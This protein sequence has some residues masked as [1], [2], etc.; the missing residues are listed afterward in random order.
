MSDIARLK[1][2]L[3]EVEPVVLR[4]IEVPLDIKLDK[5][6]GIV[7]AAMGWE[8]YHL[9]EFRVGRSV[10][11]GTPDPNWP[12]TR[13]LPAKKASLADLLEHAKKTFA[14]VYDFGDDWMHTVKVEAI[15]P[16]K[17]DTLYPRLIAAAGRCPPEDCGGPWGYA[18]FQD[19]IADNKHENHADAVEWYGEAFDPK[20][21]DVAELT[22]NVERAARR[23]SGNKATPAVKRKTKPNL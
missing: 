23:L 5:L 6:H 22:K 18:D 19:A 13:T 9:Y 7:Q 2:T 11:Y 14:Y 8:D 15:S 12:E 3:D 1:I 16:A 17:A 10:A 20:D 21:V 4:K